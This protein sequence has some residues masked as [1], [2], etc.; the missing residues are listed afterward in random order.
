MGGD[1]RRASQECARMA[2]ISSLL[3]PRS[4]AV[5]GAS[6]RNVAAVETALASG[7]PAWGVN[8]NRDE[9]AGMR[10]YPSVAEL[11][12]VP[13]CAFLMVNHERVESAFDDAAAA[14]VRAFVVPG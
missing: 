2:G 4:I 1:P 12:E 7:I 6:P 14:G 5:V 9:V 11:P 8:P 13:E 3:E 10:C